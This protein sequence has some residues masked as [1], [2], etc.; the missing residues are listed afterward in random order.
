MKI[1]VLSLLLIAAV[2]GLTLLTGCDEGMQM[3]KPAMEKPMP[4]ETEL[5]PP[6]DPEMPEPLSREDASVKAYDIITRTGEAIE[7]KTQEWLLAFFEEK[8]LDQLP[9][10]NEVLQHIEEIKPVVF[11]E[12]GVTWEESID[13]VELFLE[14]P[15]LEEHANRGSK[16]IN[17][18]AIQLYLIFTFMNPTHT[19][20]ELIAEI[21]SVIETDGLGEFGMQ[22]FIMVHELYQPVPTIYNI[23]PGLTSADTIAEYR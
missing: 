8:G 9:S 23:L 16:I 17:I 7:L 21:R 19:K 11:E 12:T 4:P 1:S 3:M 22:I 6:M 13:L 15:F 5:E 10:D 14:D 2:F 20:E 18:G